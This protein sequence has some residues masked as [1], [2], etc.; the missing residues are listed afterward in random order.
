MGSCLKGADQEI[1]FKNAERD[2][3]AAEI[4][5]FR[6]AIQSL[7]TNL[8]EEEGARARLHKEHLEDQRRQDLIESQSMKKNSG[9]KAASLDNYSGTRKEPRKLEAEM[10][11]YD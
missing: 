8:L 4:E 11:R 2:P 10:P 5:Q 6:E 9:H 7:K 3:A 1:H